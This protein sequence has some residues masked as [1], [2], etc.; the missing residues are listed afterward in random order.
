LTSQ[1]YRAV[2]PLWPQLFK[3]AD[4]DFVA[5]VAMISNQVVQSLRYGLAVGDV[6][7]TEIIP[8]LERTMRRLVGNTMR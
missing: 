2:E 7:V 3:H 5:D 6:E 4:E 1:G 8:T